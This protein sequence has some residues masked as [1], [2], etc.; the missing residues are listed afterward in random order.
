M[1][2]KKMPKETI[3]LNSVDGI[4]K[5]ISFK[6]EKLN[7]RGAQLL[8]DAILSACE[9]KYKKEKLSGKDYVK[10]MEYVKDKLNIYTCLLCKIEKGFAEIET[11]YK[12]E[13]Q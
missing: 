6:I 8:G 9:G 2:M 4:K 1:E 5:Y 7:Q 13:N 3:V 12:M 11:D 10:E